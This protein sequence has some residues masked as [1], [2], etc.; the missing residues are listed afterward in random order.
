MVHF[1]A[2]LIAYFRV[3][4]CE[5][6]DDVV[7]IVVITIGSPEN[8]LLPHK[9]HPTITVCCPNLLVFVP[10][11]WTDFETNIRTKSHRVLIANLFENKRRNIGTIHTICIELIDTF[12]MLTARSISLF[13][14]NYDHG[15]FV[16]AWWSIYY[17]GLKPKKKWKQQQQQQQVR[18]NQQ[19]TMENSLGE[20]HIDP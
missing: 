12:N 8:R 2:L 18:T 7:V 6:F 3:W 13:N 10:F 5:C 1:Q 16:Q 19:S 4:M 14:H 20:A 9:R 11:V 17:E 15:V